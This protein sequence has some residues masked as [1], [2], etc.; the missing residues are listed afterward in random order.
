[1]GPKTSGSQTG[2][3]FRHPLVEM[4][5][6]KHPLVKLADVMDWELIERAFG[7]HFASTTGRPAL[8]PRLVAGLL[9]LQHAYDCS[10]EEIVNTWMENPYVQYFTGETYFQ[11]EAP[12]DSSSLTRWRKR[13][14][15]EGVESMLMVTID[16]AQ[17]LGAVKSS[18][19]DRLI[20][21]TTVM[22]K[23]IAYPTDS[24]LLERSRQHLVRLA[25]A[26][27]IELRQNYNREAPR[28]ALQI[29]RYAHAKQFKRMHRMVKTLK[30]RVGRVYRDVQRNFDVIPQEHRAKAN[31]LLM[32]VNRILT[33]QKKDK[34]KL[35][36]LHA[37]EVQC[38]SK[39]KAR[40]PY[41]F[42]V[43]VTVATTLKE[44]LVVG[45]R[46]MPGNPWDGH[47]LAETVEQASILTDRMPKTVIVDRGYQ[48]VTV[49]GVQILRSG[50]RRGVTRGLKAMIKRRSAIEPTIGHMKTDGRLD[51]NPLQGALGDA[52]H[53][54]VC[55][56]GHN[57]RLLMKKLRLLWPD[58][59]DWL[60][61]ETG[62][63]MVSPFLL[64]A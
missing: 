36:A 13:I 17:K 20:V 49:D 28:M 27:G 26:H 41:E 57:I 52:L 64:A 60:A 12:L 10:D 25:D 54:L 7:A 34:N 55:G 18:S 48:G 22:P 16:A 1:M 46:S 11:T 42:G 61:A 24:R 6:L 38:I 15:E 56:A 37:P 29:G 5:S 43:K 44:G 33:Q 3:L 35:Y 21:D 32:R 39:G 50:Q 51:R 59:M 8:S 19:F 58:I 23:A 9:Y 47:T 63:N 45:M 4:I 62:G 53:A 14:G 2:D 31:D 30:T 40:T